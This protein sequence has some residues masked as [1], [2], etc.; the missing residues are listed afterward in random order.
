MIRMAENTADGVEVESCQTVTLFFEGGDPITESVHHYGGPGWQLGLGGP[1]IKTLYHSR[2][3]ALKARRAK[4]LT[5]LKE[6]DFKIDLEI[7]RADIENSST[8]PLVQR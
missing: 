6:L 3:E 5:T 8:N 1:Y 7:E 2:L 4:L